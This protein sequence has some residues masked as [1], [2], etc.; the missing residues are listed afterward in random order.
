MD[1]CLL[2][3]VS[4]KCKQTLTDICEV[5]VA[6]SGLSISSEPSTSK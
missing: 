1:K 2:K 6:E 3:L 5:V 4:D